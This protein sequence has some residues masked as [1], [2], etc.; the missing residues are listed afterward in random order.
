MKTLKS[1]F[2]KIPYLQLRRPE[3]QISGLTDDSRDVRP[4]DL[5]V[6]CRGLNHDG[7]DFIPQAL[8]KGAIA[9]VSER[10]VE[11]PE[12]VG[13]VLVKNSRDILGE[14]A[15]SF[16]DSPS[17]R[18]TLVGITGTNGKTSTAWFIRYMLSKLGFKVGLLGTIHYDLGRRILPAK[19]TSP[20]P[21]RLHRYLAEMVSSNISHV[22][23]EVSSHALDQKRLESLSFQVAGFTNLSRDHLDYHHCIEK[24]FE[25]K[26]RLFRDY[27]DLYGKAVI[28][29][30][31]KWGR[32]LLEIVGKKAITVGRGSS[33]NG[34]VLARL[35]DGYSF[36]IKF[37]EKEIVLSTKLYGDF[38][39]ENLLI[40][41]ATGIALNLDFEDL[42]DALS[43]V[44]A[45]P[46][47]LELVGKK[48]DAFIFVDYAH[49]PHALAKALESLR[50]FVSNRLFCVFG[51]GGDRDRGKRSLMGKVALELAD[52]VILTSD[53]PRN[54]DPNI[55]IADILSGMNGATPLVI[56]DRR[57]AIFEA[58]S[59]LRPGDVLLVAGKGHE[60]YQEIKGRRYPFSDQKLIREFLAME[61]A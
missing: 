58:I 47:R 41:V 43:D 20:P 30:S 54:E 49:T 37:K 31:D 10:S 48:H 22:V 16:Y 25:A 24:Y 50:P 55:I 21:I 7:H 13:F 17:E 19:E 61:A 1:L 29:V 51:C 3:T 28:N 18:L 8:E 44:Q 4:G 33:L 6:A 57:E 60:D 36:L 2:Q 45:P 27:L 46:G 53:N 56:P 5:F 52:Q 34:K 26:T 42:V 38:Q 32:K 9:I 40:A 15:S 11:L 12:D 14:I 59:R 23:M 35:P 39:L